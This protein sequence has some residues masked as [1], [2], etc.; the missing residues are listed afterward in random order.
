MNNQGTI[1][2]L[3][4]APSVRFEPCLVFHADHVDTDV[5]GGC[6]WPADDHEAPAQA[7]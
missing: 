3:P 6:G 7:A 5:C 1:T 2:T 4:L